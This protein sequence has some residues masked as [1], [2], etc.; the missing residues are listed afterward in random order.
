MLQ[1]FEVSRRLGLKI[2]IFIISKLIKIQIFKPNLRDTSKYCSKS[3]F[4]IKF[5]L[6]KIINIKYQG[7]Y[8]GVFN[9]KFK[10]SIEA[11]LESEGKQLY[12]Q[13]N[14]M[15]I[16]KSS[17]NLFISVSNILRKVCAL[18]S[19]HVSHHLSGDTC[20]NNHCL[21]TYF[22]YHNSKFFIYMKYGFVL[23]L[24]FLFINKIVKFL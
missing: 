8:F 20:W 14:V 12:D 3:V 23:V 24:I 11:G 17:F 21:I 15:H 5:S 13:D 6:K 2:C 7:C 19:Q 4:Q 10:I 22:I 9:S 1:Y 16:S 18:S